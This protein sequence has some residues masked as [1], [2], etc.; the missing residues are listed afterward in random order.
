MRHIV[1][2]FKKWT[3]QASVPLQDESTRLLPIQVIAP[4]ILDGN[5]QQEIEIEER[6]AGASANGQAI[7]KS[8][9]AKTTVAQSMHKM[10]D[11]PFVE[12]LSNLSL[13][14]QLYCYIA[15]KR[16]ALLLNPCYEKLRIT[17]IEQL[18]LR[19]RG[20]AAFNKL[21]PRFR[22]QE[23][24]FIR[25]I[26]NPVVK[27]LKQT[28]RG[29]LPLD[30]ANDQTFQQIL[31]SFPAVNTFFINKK[32]YPF[33]AC[34]ALFVASLAILFSYFIRFE[35]GVVKMGINGMLQ[36]LFSDS[37]QDFFVPV[38]AICQ[39]SC[40]QFYQL[41]D[42][43][44]DFGTYWNCISPLVNDSQWIDG[45]HAAYW[46]IQNFIQSFFMNCTSGA[47][48][49]NAYAAVD[50]LYSTI[51]RSVLEACTAVQNN[52]DYAGN[53]VLYANSTT[54]FSG[55]PN[56]I[57]YFNGGDT[58]QQGILNQLN[59]TFSVD[60]TLALVHTEGFHA[61]IILACALPFSLA[62]ATLFIGLKFHENGYNANIAPEN[63]DVNKLSYLLSRFKYGSERQVTAE[64]A[65]SDLPS[66]LCQ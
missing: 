66:V 10:P 53:K 44:W 35:E 19:S 54:A 47:A 5:I 15:F 40:G 65:A 46:G 61:F 64:I 55:N 33:F 29:G 57:T 56:D 43:G 22:F 2:Y 17:M 3:N 27:Q 8:A 42:K 13:I 24:F 31:D 6:E 58:D 16:C 28:L 11:I 32:L 36:K 1:D 51:G 30:H 25:A 38:N 21:P 60:S 41:Q 23:K 34:A 59:F 52:G 49:N 7:K 45:E 63:K 62:I 39:V 48:M 26:Q 4:A 14:D 37:A 20:Q 50:T 18:F 9:L 12:I